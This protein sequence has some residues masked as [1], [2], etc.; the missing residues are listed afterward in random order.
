MREQLWQVCKV[1]LTAVRWWGA[2][3]LFAFAYF[4]LQV[5]LDTSTTKSENLLRVILPS[6]YLAIWGIQIAKPQFANSQMRLIPGYH[7]PHLLVLTTALVVLL[8]INPLI[9]AYISNASALS[10]VSFSVA[11]MTVAVWS[12]AGSASFFLLAVI[13]VAM[14]TEF[15]KAFW[16]DPKYGWA[17]LLALIAGLIATGAWLRRLTILTE[18]MPDYETQPL[19]DERQDRAKKH[20][21]RGTKKTGFARYITDRWHDRLPMPGTTVLQ[22]FRLFHYGFDSLPFSAVAVLVAIAATVVAIWITGNSDH[23]VSPALPAILWLTL[24]L[25]IAA[26]SSLATRTEWIAQE[27]VLP[28][29]RR[30][31][32]GQL[33]AVG[34]KHAFL[35]WLIGVWTATLIGLRSN[36]YEREDLPSFVVAFACLSAAVQVP[37]FGFGLLLALSREIVASFFGLALVAVGCLVVLLMWW[38]GRHL[39]PNWDV[40]AGL[41]M[42]LVPFGIF[43]IASARE[44]WLNAELG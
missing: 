10:A 4:E 20:A 16:D 11:L 9:L 39:S 26:A 28:V 30:E 25:P 23:E 7:G 44:L 6:F 40:V 19:T 37:V 31:R 2:L 21:A 13:A 27:G 22:R 5:I 33:F 42:F 29:T 34:A 32:I 36:S 41:A 15:G 24:L 38:D 12:Y 35:L 17:H 8:I 14:V 3:V 18:E 1:Y 43:L